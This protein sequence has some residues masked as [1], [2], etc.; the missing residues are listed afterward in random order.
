ME[1]F[2]SRQANAAGRAGN[3]SDFARE[4]SGFSI[5]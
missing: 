2:R 5:A 4:G 3:D 1:Q